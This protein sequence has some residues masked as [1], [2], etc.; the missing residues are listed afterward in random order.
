MASQRWKPSAV[1]LGM[2][3][4]TKDEYLRDRVFGKLGSPPKIVESTP[5]GRS[6]GANRDKKAR[7]KD[8]KRKRLNAIM[9]R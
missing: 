4:D 9:S 2:A 7:N 5:D 1:L 6:M 3:A 8:L